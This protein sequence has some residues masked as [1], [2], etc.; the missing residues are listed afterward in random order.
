MEVTKVKFERNV[1]FREAEDV[2]RRRT[3]AA[4]SSGSGNAY[5]RAVAPDRRVTYTSIST[6][7]D[8]TWPTNSSAPSCLEPSMST[9][10]AT[11]AAQTESGIS[12]CKTDV[13]QR[14]DTPAAVVGASSKLPSSTGVIP[15]PPV[16]PPPAAAG[17][18]V[19]PGKT[20]AVRR[21]TQDGALNKGPGKAAGAANR[22]G[23]LVEMDVGVS[24]DL[25]VQFKK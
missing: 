24:D 25:D 9:Q 3:P 5:A 17:G 22:F 4:A 12:P 7:T 8:L 20:G 1:S 15:I 13:T 11:V 6:Q 23:A 10:R 18:S 19:G 21:V 2:V 14:L 16:K